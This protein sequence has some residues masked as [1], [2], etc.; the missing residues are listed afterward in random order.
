MSN[1]IKY[2]EASLVILP[3]NKDALYNLGVTYS[4]MGDSA[5]AIASYRKLINYFPDHRSALNNLGTIFITQNKFDSAYIY[6]KRSYDSDTTFP[7]SSQN[8][9]IYFFKLKDY[10]HAIQYA[11]NAIR[12]EKNMKI[13]YEIIMLKKLDCKAF[14]LNADNADASN[15]DFY[16][17]F[18][19]SV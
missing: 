8:L 16:W 19:K 11:S 4:E 10:T 9:A 6:L 15:A 7:K 13:S 12:L 2:T 17:F 14:C 5:N 3:T 1:A 18:K